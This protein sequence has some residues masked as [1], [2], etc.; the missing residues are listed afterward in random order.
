MS[1]HTQKQDQWAGKY[2]TN[3]YREYLRERNRRERLNKEAPEMKELL[4]HIVSDDVSRAAN[5]QVF[6][7]EILSRIEGGE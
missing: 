5:W 2:N 4:E 1:K 3:E 6:A 7:R